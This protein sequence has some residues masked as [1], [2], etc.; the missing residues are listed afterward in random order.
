[1][2]LSVVAIA[3]S[4]SCAKDDTTGTTNNGTSDI[5]NPTGYASRGYTMG[6]YHPEKKVKKIS[7]SEYTKYLAPDNDYYYEYDDS[8]DFKVKAEFTWDGDNLKTITIGTDV[9]N[10]QYDSLGYISSW[11]WD[12]KRYFF[13]YNSYYS[14]IT[15]YDKNDPY[16]MLGWDFDDNGI[17]TN[18]NYSYGTTNV[19]MVN[20][21]AVKIETYNH[22]TFSYSYDNKKNPFANLLMPSHYGYRGILKE[23]DIIDLI[24]IFAYGYNYRDEYSNKDFLFRISKNNLIPKNYFNSSNNG[25]HNVTF[26]VAYSS[27]GWPVKLVGRVVDKENGTIRDEEVNTVVIEYYD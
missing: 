5:D 26:N 20:G 11:N 23:F 21:N 3:A 12:N 16:P 15:E 6:Y 27:D 22:D 17:L 8:T 1:M 7:Y 2:M 4:T 25:S 14:D 13:E 9:Y 10:C 19:T 24:T 18:V